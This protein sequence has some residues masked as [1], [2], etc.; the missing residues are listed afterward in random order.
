M[1]KRPQD[2]EPARRL[3]SRTTRKQG[4]KRRGG[5]QTEP[6]EI[7][8][9]PAQYLDTMVLPT[10]AE[11]LADLGNPRRAYLACMMAAHLVDQITR[12]ERVDKPA[13][14]TAIAALGGYKG[15]ALE[16]V[17]G[18]CNGTKHAGTGRGEPFPFA[19]GHEKRRFA[20]EFDVEGRGFDQGD[21]DIPGL[22]VSHGGA[23]YF[24]DECVRA[25]VWGFIA[26]YPDRFAG[27]DHASVTKP[28]LDR[29]GA[30]VDGGT[31]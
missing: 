16:I 26:A 24:I 28:G 15:E 18:I 12:S 3:D 13:V 19:P 29:W 17:E 27:V 31:S 7:V 2:E 9:T 20:L 10:L 23:T 8:L 6:A 21:W 14:R 25:T 4:S 1:T 11:F 5:P 22:T 30:P